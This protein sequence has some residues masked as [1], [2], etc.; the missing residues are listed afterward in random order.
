[1]NNKLDV[2]EQ[3]K[4]ICQPALTSKL[5][6][7]CMFG[8]EDVTEEQLWECLKKKKWKRVK[9]GKKL[10]EMVNDILS[11]TIS[12]YMSYITIEAY[13][14]PSLFSEEGKDVLNQLL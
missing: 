11:L 9:E 4:A 3:F 14:A 5:E 8:Y 12:E 10:Y 7:F 6:E 13:K 2:L 1:M